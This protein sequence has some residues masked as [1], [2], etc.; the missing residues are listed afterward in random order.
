MELLLSGFTKAGAYARCRLRRI[1]S[2]RLCGR[3]DA[4]LLQWVGYASFVADAN[5]K[6]NTLKTKTKKC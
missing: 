2:Y 6:D 3:D 1:K 4:A 5:L